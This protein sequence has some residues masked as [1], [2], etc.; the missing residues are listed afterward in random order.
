[1]DN[2]LTP[3]LPSIFFL[4]EGR[5]QS[6]VI[7][8]LSLGMKY[9]PVIVRESVWKVID[10][11]LDFPF[12][13]ITLF[14]YIFCSKYITKLKIQDWIE[15]IAHEEW[16]RQ[17]IGNKTPKAIQWYVGYGFDFLFNAGG[18]YHSITH[19][20]RAYEK[21][22]GSCSECSE[23]LKLEENA[24]LKLY[25]MQG[26]SDTERDFEISSILKRNMD[27]ISNI[28]SRASKK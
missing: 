3:K 15:L 7:T 2:L 16:H 8:F 19:E 5:L 22:C 10:S 12:T 6:S 9:D 20:K 11:N 28:R 24:I 14:D 26:I 4:P 13:A 21:G 23:L 25:F 17:E 1:M 18:S 27:E